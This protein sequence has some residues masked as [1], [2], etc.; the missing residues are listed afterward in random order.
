M[1]AEGY[2]QVKIIS[3]Q[4]IKVLG[5]ATP[6]ILF[7]RDAFTKRV[8]FTKKFKVALSCKADWSDSTIDLQLRGNTDGYY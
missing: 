7:A 2:G 5:E 1:A 4:Q 6:L 3:S 8:K